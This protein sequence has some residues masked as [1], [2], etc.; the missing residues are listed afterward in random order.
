L[1]L[2]VKVILLGA[3][4]LYFLDSFKIFWVEQT[5]KN[6]FQFFFQVLL[7]V[8]ARYNLVFVCWFEHGQIMTNSR[9]RGKNFFCPCLDST[10]KEDS[11]FLVRGL[12][13]PQ[14]PQGPHGKNKKATALSDDGSICAG[15]NLMG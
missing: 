15:G 9:A 2:V 6:K 5:V 8:L 10:R 11:C 13:G 7:H 14:G 1:W 12:T 4:L 3:N